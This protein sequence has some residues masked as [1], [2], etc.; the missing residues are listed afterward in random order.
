[1]S[2]IE[3]AVALLRELHQGD[4]PASAIAELAQALNR[5]H[6]PAQRAASSSQPRAKRTGEQ[7]QR[8]ITKARPKPETQPES[9][10]HLPTDVPSHINSVR[11]AADVER[12]IREDPTKEWTIAEMSRAAKC[13][14]MTSTTHLRRLA[15]TDPRVVVLVNDKPATYRLYDPS[16]D[17]DTE[18]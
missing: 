18:E 10:Q 5:A 8:R 4:V 14:R 2:V 6:G 9:G 11:I 16:T 15:L 12:L 17:D 3:T 7:Y 1:M 13:T